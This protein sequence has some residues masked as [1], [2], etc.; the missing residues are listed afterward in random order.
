[1]KH[2]KTFADDFQKIGRVL[3]K[4]EKAKVVVI[5]YDN[6]DFRKKSNDRKHAK[7]DIERTMREWENE[8]DYD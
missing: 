2:Q 6:L 8:N 5:D 1:M 7:N 3:R 4:K